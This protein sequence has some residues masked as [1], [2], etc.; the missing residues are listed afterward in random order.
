MPEMWYVRKG[1][2][3]RK[4]LR[5]FL[6]RYRY[7]VL[8]SQFVYRVY[9]DH[10]FL[11]LTDGIMDGVADLLG[12]FILLPEKVSRLKIAWFKPEKYGYKELF[13]S[14]EDEF[15]YAEGNNPDLVEFVNK[16]GD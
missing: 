3:L 10:N 12:L 2:D 7:V 9:Y 15:D 6:Y 5:E 14:L 13:F 8:N 1:E 16:E 11:I 4:T